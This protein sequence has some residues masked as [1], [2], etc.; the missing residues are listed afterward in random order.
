LNSTFNDRTIK[1][2]VLSFALEPK[3]N[4]KSFKIDVICKLV[5]NF[6]SE[7]FNK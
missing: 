3:D 6:Y 4:F 2:L 7:D 1:L 5:D